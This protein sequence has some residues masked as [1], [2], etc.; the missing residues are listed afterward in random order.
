M[1]HTVFN[2]GEDTRGLLTLTFSIIFWRL[3]SSLMIPGGTVI[4]LNPATSFYNYLLIPT[5]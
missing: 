3:P 2:L 1:I 5:T 4:V